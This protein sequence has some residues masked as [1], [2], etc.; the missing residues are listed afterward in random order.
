MKV[1]SI[2]PIISITNEGIVYNQLPIIQN[3]MN[4]GRAIPDNYDRPMVTHHEGTGNF[5]ARRY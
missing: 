3:C 2:I 4:I 1:L 5:Y